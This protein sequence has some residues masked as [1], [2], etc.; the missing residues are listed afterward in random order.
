MFVEGVSKVVVDVI[1]FGCRAFEGSNT[2]DLYVQ[3]I[4]RT[5]RCL[6]SMSV[7]PLISDIA[8]LEKRGGFLPVE[9][10]YFIVYFSLNYVR[11]IM[12]S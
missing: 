1:K 10:L 6:A 12:V 8:H 2:L 7:R 4:I 5:L 9:F 3:C 11:I